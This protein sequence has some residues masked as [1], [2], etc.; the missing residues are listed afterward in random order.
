M[1]DGRHLKKS[2]IGHISGTVLP[3]FAKF[4]VKTHSW[5]LKWTGSRNSQLLKIQD[6]GRPPSWKS[7]IGHIS[8]TVRPIFA[9]FGRKTHIVP[10]NWTGS[11][12][13]QLLKIQDQK[14]VISPELFDRSSQNFVWSHILGFRSGPEVKIFNFCKSKMAYGRHLEKSKICYISE[15]V[16]SI[17]AKFGR[18]TH[19][20]PL[21]WTRS[22]NFQN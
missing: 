14:S 10:P 1:A 7:K 15:T 12:N 21:N 22:W 11:R 4:C 6:S 13:F 18:M 8:R 9:K 20:V 2:K 5:P 17:F 19:I 3:I 16:Q